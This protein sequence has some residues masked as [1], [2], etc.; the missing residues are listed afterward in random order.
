MSIHHSES[1]QTSINKPKIAFVIT[2]LTSGGAERVLSTLANAFVE[3]YHVII[4][5]LYDVEP[6]Y[7]LNSRITRISCKKQYNQNMNFV[8]SLSNN[9]SMVK[10]IYK[11]IKKEQIALAIGFMTTTNV[12]TI[13]ACKLAKIPCLISERTHPEYDPISNFWSQIRQ[14]TYPYCSKL[15]IQTESIK[16]Y[17][18]NFLDANKLAVIKNPISDALLKLHDDSIVKKQIILSV[19]RLD[20]VKNQQLL[21]EAFA[22][23][24]TENWKIQ[25]VG[26]GPLEPALAARIKQLNLEESVE[27]IGSVD[28]IHEYYN[29]AEIFAFTSNFEGFPNALLE[30]MAFGL[31]CVS[32]NC[33]SGPSEV[34]DDGEN[35][36]LVPV[37]D[38]DM[39]KRKLEILMTNPDLREKFGT[40][41]KKSTA[42]YDTKNITKQWNKL[43]TEAL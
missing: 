5:T 30:A 38:K 31:P 21:I 43:I 20:P 23:M 39:L 13:L 8:D 33:P 7:A 37:G 29:L 19:G 6:F 22:E 2:S 16:G 32:T 36:F 35:G 40:A 27:L 3:T 26:E 34:I 15:I 9:F 42:K 10:G 11:I 24:N 12:Y 28:G 4:I 41:A 17:F 18:N 25:I 14:K 1:E